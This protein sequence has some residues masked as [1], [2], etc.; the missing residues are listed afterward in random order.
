MN[1][2]RQTLFNI[3]RILVIVL[4]IGN[5]AALFVFHYE[6]PDFITDLTNKR[7]ASASQDSPSDKKASND[8]DAK[9]KITYSFKFD[10][11]T[12]SYDGTSK[13]D[14][15]SGVSIVSSKDEKADNSEIFA[16][17]K[18]GDS[19]SQKII[20]YTADTEEGQISGTRALELTGYNGP[21]IKLPDVFP[22]L[23]DSQLDSV[24]TV[25]PSDGSFHAD[26]G[27]GGD[28]T[29][30]VKASYKRD[31][32]DNNLV[33]FTFTVTNSFNDTVSA[34]K[35]VNLIRTKPVI[36]LK[37]SAVTVALHSQFNALEYVS[38]AEDVDGSSLFRSII[39]DGSANTEAAGEYI[40]TYKVS[41]PS[42]AVSD[43]K[44]LKVTVQ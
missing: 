21:S 32:N 6:L 13:L 12:I 31:E 22:Q 24:L 8:A 33:H 35:D 18:T 9:E 23:E 15:L 28:I 10:T 43:P 26:D 19:V 29:K 42:G 14:L 30:A 2:K 34:E 17:I 37:E 40:L 16:H 3:I 39:I 38:V 36:A 20:E 1:R 41:S 11:D 25:M 44:E 7:S 5:L 27:Y 4:A